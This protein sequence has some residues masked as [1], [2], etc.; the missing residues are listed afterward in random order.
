MYVKPPIYRHSGLALRKSANIIRSIATHD[1][2]PPVSP[3]RCLV[4]YASS[5]DYLKRLFICFTD[6]FTV[7]HLQ[8]CQKRWLRYSRCLDSHSWI[9]GRLIMVGGNRRGFA[10]Y[11]PLDAPLTLLHSHRCGEGRGG[12]VFLAPPHVTSWRNSVNRSAG[13]NGKGKTREYHIR[14]EG[15]LG[16]GIIF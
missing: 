12:V 5:Y 14:C 1:F 16:Q 8:R 2:P 7:Y 4:V 10:C 15:I 9:L 13:S 3:N 11:L 6:I